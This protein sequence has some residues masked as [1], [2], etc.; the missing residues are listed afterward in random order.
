MFERVAKL[1]VEIK[2]LKLLWVFKIKATKLLLLVELKF[3]MT[4][5]NL[6]ALS[7]SGGEGSSLAAQ[8]AQLR[9]TRSFTHAG[10]KKEA[11][12]SLWDLKDALAPVEDLIPV[13]V[14]ALATRP[15]WG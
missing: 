15:C 13:D 10:E 2:P 11:L 4:L 9:V 7:S 3:E 5:A 12:A 1:S 14:Q 8:E 6:A